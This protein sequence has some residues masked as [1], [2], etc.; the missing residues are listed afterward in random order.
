MQNQRNLIDSTEQMGI[1]WVDGPSD[2]ALD[3]A[4]IRFEAEMASDLNLEF[5]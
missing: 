5:D 4:P 3:A 2:G 1:R